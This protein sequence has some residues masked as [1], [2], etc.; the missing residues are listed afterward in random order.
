MSRLG[1]RLRT[2]REEQGLS[3]AQVASATRILPRYIQ[4]LEIGD[5]GSLPGDVYARGF[6]RNYAQLLR[7][8][9]EELILQYRQERGEPT[10]RIQVVPAAAPPRNRSCLIPSV[11]FFGAFFV[12]IV[13]VAMA[14]FVAETTGLLAPATV[15]DTTGTATPRRANPT[16]WPTTTR[17]PRT[18]ADASAPDAS[19]GPLS[20]TDIVNTAITDVVGP[21]MT[22]TP[23]APPATATPTP[24]N[25]IQVVISVLPGGQS[26]LTMQI[27]GVTRPVFDALIPQGQPVPGLGQREVF[28]NIGDTSAVTLTVN[29][30]LC[31]GFPKGVRGVPQ[32]I[33]LTTPTCPAP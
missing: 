30:Q 17:L 7:L 22:A 3:L 4:A 10:G 26:W 23:T 32:R 6:I 29:G 19:A 11:S 20:A 2:A 14:Y 28:V 9:A 33:T 12:I 5:L 21:P 16:T 18:T 27:D 25:G 31:P 1:E 15:A 24:I 8:P 13:L